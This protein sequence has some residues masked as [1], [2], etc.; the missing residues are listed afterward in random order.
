MEDQKELKEKKKTK[1]N[2]ELEELTNLLKKVQ[3]D[4]EN[5][6]KRVEKERQEFTNFACLEIIETLLPVLDSFELAL[7]NSPNK[8]IEAIYHQF[9]NLLSA[10]G[11]AKIEA[12]GKKFDPFYHEALMQ[13]KSDK[14]EETVIEELQTGYTLNG[15]VIRT[16][17]V[18]IAMKNEGNI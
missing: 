16:S 12:L 10:K 18:K 9:W 6:K 5:F 3:A 4:F 17:K 14:E 13:E 1:E 7:K 2:K 8:D 15:R 11:L